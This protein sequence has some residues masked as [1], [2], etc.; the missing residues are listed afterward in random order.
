M[1]GVRKNGAGWQVS[2]GRNIQEYYPN[3]QDAINR[4]LELEKAY[5]SPKSSNRKDY[6]GQK[7]KNFEILGDSGTI[8]G[9]NQ[10]V[11]AK[12]LITNEYLTITM[13]NL[14]YNDSKGIN[15][16][17]RND[18]NTSGYTGVHKARKKYNASIGIE[19]ITYSLGNYSTKEQASLVYELAKRDW[20]EK[21]IKP[22]LRSSMKKM[23]KGISKTPY[24]T[25]RATITFKGKRII[26]KTFKTLPEAIEALE[27]AKQQLK[28]TN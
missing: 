9:H 26:H 13:S 3:E 7:I 12:N 21:R 28:E 19:G 17:G 23:P 14:K 15:G 27:Q 6:S 11:V 1:K 4:R 2:F 22:I 8:Q 16:I 25:Y 10:L 20:I 24:G 18:Q 5:G